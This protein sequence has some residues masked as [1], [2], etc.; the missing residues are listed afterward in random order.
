SPDLRRKTGGPE[1]HS[2]AE[3]AKVWNGGEGTRL[4]YL[5]PWRDLPD[6][7]FGHEAPFVK[8]WLREPWRDPWQL[9]REASRTVV[10][11]LNVCGWYD[12][13]NGSI[14]LHGAITKVG[15]SAVARNHSTLIIGPWS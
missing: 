15:A 5:L 9:D 8:G 10:P 11:N 1:P 12:H 14:D 7:I 13:C 2:S 3:A 6:D 4:L